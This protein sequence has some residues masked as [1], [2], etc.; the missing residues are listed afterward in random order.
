MVKIAK[1]FMNR[2]S[3]AVRLPADFRFSGDEIYIRKDKKTG[4]V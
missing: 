2:R 1:I 4:D 3:Q